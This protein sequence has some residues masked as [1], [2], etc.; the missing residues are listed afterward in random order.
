MNQT[1]A[2]PMLSADVALS[3]L[4]AQAIE[5]RHDDVLHGIWN[6][7][8]VETLLQRDRDTASRLRRLRATLFPAGLARSA[9]RELARPPQVARLA[10]QLTSEARSLL[11]TISIGDDRTLLDAFWEWVSLAA[12]LQSMRG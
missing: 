5:A 12:H 2:V 10:Q 6:A 11:A 3:H 7:L 8:T 4:L 9:G 1:H